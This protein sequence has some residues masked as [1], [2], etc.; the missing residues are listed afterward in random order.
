MG[1]NKHRVCMI[2]QQRDVKGGIAAVTNGYYNSKIETDYDV[3]YVE[4]YCDTSRVKMVLK[5]LGAYREFSSVLKEFK[6]ELVHIHSSFGGSF[7]RMQPFIYM[8]RK[9]GIPILNHCHGADFETFYVKAS[10]KKKSR[11]KDVFSNFTKMVVLS[12]EWKERLSAIFPKERMVVINNYCKPRPQ[13]E[14]EKQLEKRFAARQIL[15]LGELGHRKGGYDFAGIVEKVVKRYPDVRFI[16]AGS[17]S[18]E[19]ESN[20]RGLIEKSG[21]SENCLFPGWIRGETKDKLLQEST[22]FILPSYQEGLPMAIL[23]AMAYGLPVVSTNVGGIPQLILNG[24]NG[25]T[26]EP[27]DCETIADEICRIM[28]SIETYKKLSTESY[29]V[30]RGKFGFDAHLSKLEAVY[31]ELLKDIEK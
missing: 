9:R 24:E 21:V 23:D 4:S 27:G 31:D 22:A 28:D 18:K 11:I 29:R 12:E 5:A 3:R 16:F 25:Y 6:P 1:E 15:F 7:Y 13:S 14:I 2:V 8:A 10:D 20:I 30:A 17:G 19:D 26:A